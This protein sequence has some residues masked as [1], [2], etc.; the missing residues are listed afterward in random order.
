LKT[1]LLKRL[2][3]RPL[4]PFLLED[5]YRVIPAFNL[6]GVDYYQF[7]SAFEIPAGRAMN[8]LTIFE[9]FNMRCTED[10][11]RKHCRAVDILLS[12]VSGKIS[13]NDIALLHRNLKERLDMVQMPDHIYKLASVMFFDKSE[14]P[15]LYDFAYNEK[16][17]AAWKAAPDTLD[18]FLRTPFKELIPSLRLHQQNVKT[19]FR[20]AEQADKLHQEDLQAVL[21]K[22]E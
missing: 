11:L 10:Y 14:S 16:K 8:T 17:I 7:D 5:K 2:F 4:K 21:S 12:G 20:V 13:L 1:N 18:F 22:A 9:E 15:Y 6:N 3:R 19:F